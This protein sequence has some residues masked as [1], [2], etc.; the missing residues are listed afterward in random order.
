MAAG[1][2][3]CYLET[4]LTTE[5]F[6]KD[7]LRA[8]DLFIGKNGDI[9]DFLEACKARR[10]DFFDVLFPFLL[11]RSTDPARTGRAVN[12]SR[13]LHGRGVGSTR[14]ALHILVHHRHFIGKG[15]NRRRSGVWWPRKLRPIVSFNRGGGGRRGFF[16]GER[17]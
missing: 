13:F 2:R 3:H 17:W 11:R 6:C 8:E 16:F 5:V 9:L 12:R 10:D 7:H 14:A 15:H 1:A 4:V